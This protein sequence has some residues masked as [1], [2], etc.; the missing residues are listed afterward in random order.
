MLRS[1]VRVRALPAPGELRFLRAHRRPFP[2]TP[3]VDRS[4]ASSLT[5][6]RVVPLDGGF[7]LELGPPTSGLLA[8][9]GDARGTRTSPVCDLGMR[10]PAD[11]P[12]RA[13][14]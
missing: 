5:S 8:H 3:A 14:V 11:G 2:G 1:L 13:A 7:G 4:W 12:I 10:V 6:L 9:A